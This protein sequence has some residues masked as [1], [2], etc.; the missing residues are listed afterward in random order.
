MDKK[1]EN[2]PL[3]NF[4]FIHHGKEYWYSRSVACTM[5][6]FSKNKEGEWCVLANKRG[7]GTP[8]YQGFWNLVSGYLDFNENGEQCIQREVYEETGLFINLNKIQ[9]LNVN[10]D[11]KN[12]RQNVSLQ[13]YSILDNQVNDFNTENSETNEVSEISWIPISKVDNYRWAFG[14]DNLIK[15]FNLLN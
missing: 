2:K 7:E 8:D 4:P 10:T 13:Y 5:L 15:N 14:H 11:P 1:W 3:Q 9:F 6:A 12:N